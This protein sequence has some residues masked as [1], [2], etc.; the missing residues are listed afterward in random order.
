MGL[1]EL[2]DIAAAKIE[3]ERWL[4]VVAGLASAE[5]GWFAGQVIDAVGR[6]RR[7]DARWS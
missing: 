4:V 1:Q 6:V 7:Q 5:S 3:F 2:G